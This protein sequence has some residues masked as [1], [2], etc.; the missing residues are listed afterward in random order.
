MKNQI[1]QFINEG[2]ILELIKKEG[3]YKT[4]KNELD[5]YAYLGNLTEDTIFQTYETL[6]GADF[7]TSFNEF[8]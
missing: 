7:S 2:K 6:I 5:K 4:Y 1:E 8:T 3:D